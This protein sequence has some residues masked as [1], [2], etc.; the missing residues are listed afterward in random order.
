M[1][2]DCPF[3]ARWLGS[4]TLLAA[5][6][7]SGCAPAL[8][9][10]QVRPDGAGLEA[11][12]P[13][14]PDSHARQATLAGHSVRMT[15]HA[16]TAGGHTYALG[17]ADVVDPAQVPAALDALRA[18]ATANLGGREVAD[19]ALSVPGMTPQPGA[20]R[21]RVAGQL[22]DGQAMAQDAAIFARGTV[23]YQ[24][25]RIGPPPT[26]RQQEDE[27]AAATFFSSLRLL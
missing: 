3:L 23:V 11:L 14:K 27:E 19:A 9:W 15:L 1:F 10:R 18:A 26:S 5:S 6:L 13:C 24:A 20:R 21:I 16:C 17:F 2:P 8:D 22:P 25:S 12:F 4:A 7:L